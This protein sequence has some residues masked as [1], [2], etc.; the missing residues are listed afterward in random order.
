M[1]TI[2]RKAITAA[3]KERKRPAGIY[4]V[5]CAA[6]GETWIGESRQVDS[7][8]N[9]LWFSLKNGSYPIRTLQAAWIQYGEQLF[10]FEVLEH[11]DD[12]L[13]PYLQQKALRERLDFWRATVP[14]WAT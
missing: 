7:H 8:R 11:L 6:T 13:T 5:R 4:A 12:D 14:V 9:R 3:Y 1:T 10:D 2:D